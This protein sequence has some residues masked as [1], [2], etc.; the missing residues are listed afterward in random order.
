MAVGEL[1]RKIYGREVEDAEL[2]KQRLEHSGMIEKFRN[3][4]TI[5]PNGFSDWAAFEKWWNMQISYLSQQW[6]SSK[7]YK[8]LVKQQSVAKKSEAENIGWTIILKDPLYRFGWE[9]D[10]I[11]NILKISERARDFVIGIL[12]TKNSPYKLPRSAKPEAKIQYNDG[13][14]RNELWIRIWSETTQE[15]LKS[16]TLWSDIQSLKKKL[17]DYQTI[18]KQTPRYLHIHKQLFDWH[19][20]NG[21]TYKQIRERALIEL[22]YRIKSNEDLGKILGRYKKRIGTRTPKSRN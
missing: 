15:D 4:W 2:I 17:H 16:K 21:L 8:K 6:R 14:G 19:F 9:I 3:V 12:V 20:L 1:H 13:T 7:E 18:K 5:P 11:L 10:Q 22:K